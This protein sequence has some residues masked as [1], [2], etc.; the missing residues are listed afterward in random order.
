MSPLEVRGL[1]P[2]WARHTGRAPGAELSRHERV[3][4]DVLGIGLEQTFPKLIG[5]AISLEDFG[6]WIVATAG[7][8]DPQ[9]VARYHAMLDDAPPPAAV[10]AEID[11]IEAADPVLDA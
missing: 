5:S 4:L 8:P 3:M 6:D 1:E 11:A 2:F 9:L 10:Q 7:P